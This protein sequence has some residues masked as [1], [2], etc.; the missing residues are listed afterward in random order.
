MLGKKTKDNNAGV[1]AGKVKM[2][3]SIKG[4]IAMMLGFGAVLTA[5]M[6]LLIIVPKVQ[7]VL[8][9]QTKNYIYDVTVSNGTMMETLRKSMRLTEKGALK[10]NFSHVGVE[11]VESSYAYVVSSKG[12]ML[13]HPSEEKI[14]QPVENEVVQGLVKTIASGKHPEPKVVE[15]VFKGETKYAAYYVDQDDIAILVVCADEKEIMKP[16]NEIASLSSVAAIVAIILVTIIGILI[17]NRFIQPILKVSDIVVKMSDMDFTEDAES[18]KLIKRKDE[19]GL[20]ARSVAT[21]RQEMISM[22]DEI[23][24]KSQELFVAS[25]R[26]D[27]DASETAKTIGQVENAVGDIADGASNQAEET[28]SATENVIIMGNMIEAT[29]AEAEALERNSDE[30]NVSSK[31][32]MDILNELIQ[33]N[34]RTKV[35]IEEIYEQTNITNASAQKIK[36]ATDL[37]ASIAEETNL[38]SLNASIEAARAGEQGRG[39]A[40]VASQIQKLAEQSN[41]SASQIDAITSALINDSTKAVDTMQQ[42]RSVMDEQT[43][44]MQQTDKM[45]RQVKNG[46]DNARSRVETISQR[47]ENLDR[48]RGQVVDVVQNLSAIAEENAASSQETAA[49]VAEVSKIVA[50]ISESAAG[51]KE[52]A[53]G[54]EESVNKFKL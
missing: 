47:T 34:E 53:H 23:R 45:F 18:A 6:I 21:L 15:Y 11:G 20:M 46:V 26:L 3:T 5:V 50:D 49:S 2:T 44:K 35:S 33:V 9:S 37:I 19:T 8:G 36:D 27:G 4:K 28:Q 52:I 42:V 1:S 22:I 12:E 41:Q 40:V 51:L 32:A 17:S 39:F 16:L 43:E 13:Y 48:S 29:N 25:E 10:E 7:D 14:G 30:M 24:G 38:L 31:N 54:L